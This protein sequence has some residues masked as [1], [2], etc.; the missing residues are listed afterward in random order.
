M[1][2][3]AFIRSSKN[4]T[5]GI[6]QV[7]NKEAGNFSYST[8]N[9]HLQHNSETITDPQVISER[10]NNCFIDTIS[11][12]LNK[13]G[14]NLTRAYQQGIKTHSASMFVSPIIEIEIKNIISKLKGKYSAGYDEIPEVL[15]KHCSEYIAKPLTHIFNL[16]V[17]R[18]IFP[19]AMK[20]AKITPL[21]KKRRQTRY[22]ELQT[23]S[24][25]S[26]LF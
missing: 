14:Y 10:F 7:I 11:D 22:S 21:F 4:K 25:S 2:N 20:I 23:N 12:L 19:D 17:K 24:C 15:V 18:G 13:G 16:S 8:Y 5:K 9:I 6:W 3:E 26:C 1:Y